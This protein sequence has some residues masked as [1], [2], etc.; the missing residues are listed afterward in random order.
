M[1]CKNCGSSIS[2]KAK[3]CPKCGEPLKNSG[4]DNVSPTVAWLLWFFFGLAGFHRFYLGRV[5]TGVLW[6]L[7]GGLFGLGWFFDL[8]AMNMMIRKANS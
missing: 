4:N 8:F 6:L 5:G 2:D 7:T 1:F 3:T